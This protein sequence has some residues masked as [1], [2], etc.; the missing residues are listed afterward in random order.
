MTEQSNRNR[1]VC[2]PESINCSRHEINPSSRSSPFSLRINRRERA[3]WPSV[4]RQSNELWSNIARACGNKSDRLRSHL[5]LSFCVRACVHQPRIQSPRVGAR[6]IVCRI[7]I[8]HC[9]STHYARSP[10][11]R[12]ITFAP[13][14]RLMFRCI[15]PEAQPFSKELSGACFETKLLIYI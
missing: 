8:L 3:E 6:C 1:H 10:N 15:K 9:L 5:L 12:C 11:V 7:S 13:C 4:I 2:D 14:K